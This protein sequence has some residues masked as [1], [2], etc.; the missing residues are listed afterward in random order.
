MK[1]DDEL[2]QAWRE[3]D[4]AAGNELFDR[5]FDGIHR[6]FANKAAANDV[7]DLVQKTFLGAVEGVREFRG[8]ASVRTYLFAIARR[9]LYKHWKRQSRD[10]DLDFGVSS[11]HDL[12]A[13]PS[14]L[15]ADREEK[16]LVL[17]AMRRLPVDLQVALELHFWEGMSGP[18]IATVLEIPEGTVR[19]RL[20]R[21]LESLRE[22]VNSLGA[23]KDLLSSTMNEISVL[24]QSLDEA[25]AR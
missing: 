22:K 18:Q 23:G 11:V 20:R 19:S 25:A 1:T 3:G 8:E 7:G 15:A 5:H 24:D 14:T 21:G 16:R 13:R 6:F 4:D 9:Q 2:I 10:G 12:G 17:E